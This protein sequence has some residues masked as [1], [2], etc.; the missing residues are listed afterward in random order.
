MEQVKKEF[1]VTPL[2]PQYW[3][4]AA[5]E[6][7]NP[8]AIIIAA[9]LIAVRVALKSVKIPL[10]DNLSIY[11]TFIPNALLGFICGPWIA[12]MAGTISDILGCLIAPSGAY[13]FPF[14]A[15]EALGS[16][17]YALFLYK[18]RLSVLRL[19]ACK[20][21]I[22]FAVNIIATPYCLSLMSGG[23]SMVA[24]MVTR[25]PKNIIL[26]P[27][28]TLILVLFFILMLPIIKKLNVAKVA[29]TK[30]AFM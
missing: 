29:S 5:R 20:L 25:V 13:F 16:F 2:N 23:K 27:F 12:L 7:A 8:K 22:N 4:A 6:L 28:E 18:T 17:L 11:I 24:Y 3:K 26:L 21:F 15:V 19:F 9:M 1:F 14:T 30:V 10:A